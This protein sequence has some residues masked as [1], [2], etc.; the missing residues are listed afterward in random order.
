MTFDREIHERM[1]ALA[2]NLLSATKAGKISWALTDQENKFLCAGSRSSVA[3]ELFAERHEDVYILSLINSRG[4]TIDTLATEHTQDAFSVND[5]WNSIL[6]DLYHFAR[7]IAHNVDE[8]IESMLADI[9]RGIPSQPPPAKR[10][11]DDPWASE[12]GDGFSD[13]P[14]F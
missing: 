13:E 6:E 7:R 9:E 10:P 2:T 11:A 4:A 3:I 12:P 5:E 8:A 14:P 1:L